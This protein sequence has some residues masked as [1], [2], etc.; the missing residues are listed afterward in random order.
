MLASHLDVGKEYYFQ[1]GDRLAMT[2]KD[3]DLIDSMPSGFVHDLAKFLRKSSPLLSESACVAGAFGF[4]AG[5]WGR[6]FYI[7]RLGLNLY[8]LVNSETGEVVSQMRKV[9]RAIANS[10]PHRSCLLRRCFNTG[11]SIR[12]KYPL[13]RQLAETPCVNMVTDEF[14][15]V[16]GRM[17]RNNPSSHMGNLWVGLKS[18]YSE[19]RPDGRTGGVI[20]GYPHKDIPNVDYPSLSVLGETT[21]KLFQR[22]FK[23]D[24]AHYG[25]LPRFI[26]VEQ[27]ALD[28]Y[29]EHD[30]QVDIELPAEMRKKLDRIDGFASSTSSHHPMEII[31]PPKLK[32]Y[33]FNLG[34]SMRERAR[35]LSNEFRG[36]MSTRVHENFL[37]LVSHL[38]V[39]R[40]DFDSPAKTPVITMEDMKWAES[41]VSQSYE[42]FIK[43]L[44]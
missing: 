32:D 17:A 42:L 8:F 9:F 36:V 2:S 3:S 1:D 10:L 29:L 21:V 27:T 38:A 26:Y 35:N 43:R 39:S 30:G 41:F 40:M 12:R 37:K 7:E 19:S 33:S 5:L 22:H 14:G 6:K 44:Q 31:I 28:R 18:L 20:F 15:E 25:L 16:Y 23:P 34:R 13:H 24:H 4:V 11:V